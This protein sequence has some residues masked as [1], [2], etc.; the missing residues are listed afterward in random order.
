M[1]SFDASSIFGAL[2]DAEQG[3]FFSITPRDT[4]GMDQK[5]SYLSGTKILPTC[6]LTQEERLAKDSHTRL[7]LKLMG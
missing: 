3:G 4:P 5:Q 1:P 2:L 7:S 6:L